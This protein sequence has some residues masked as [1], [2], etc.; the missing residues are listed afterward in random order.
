MVKGNSEVMS[1]RLRK[2]PN[3]CRLQVV[4]RCVEHDFR[5]ADDSFRM[6]N[7]ILTRCQNAL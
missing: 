4:R 6:Q 1:A 2:A 3:D 5:L 7:S